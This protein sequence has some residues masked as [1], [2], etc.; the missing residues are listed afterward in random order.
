[1]E[2]A[3]QALVRA[4]SGAGAAEAGAVRL[5]ASHVIAAEALPPILADFRRAHPAIA[6]ELAPDSRNQDLLAGEADLAVRM[7]RPTQTALVTRRIGAV[8]I[9]LYARRDYLERRGVPRTPADLEQHDLIGFDRNRE[10]LRLW[11]SVAARAGV[12]LAADR[13]AFRSDDDLVLLALLRAGAGVGGCQAPAAARDPALVPVL[14]DVF[15]AEL[16]LWLTMHEDLRA[17]RR[18]RLLFDHLAEGLSAYVA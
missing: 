9:G 16:E 7:I 11:S 13:F 12:T 14:P 15:Q 8:R 18:V 17:S 1:M 4:A 2:A 5:T 10:N 3:A 6:V